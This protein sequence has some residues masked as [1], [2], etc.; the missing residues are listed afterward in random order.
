MAL[1]R[2]EGVVLRTMRLGEA[3][4]IITLATPEHGK[5]RAVAKG[6]RKTKSRIGARLE[7]LSHVTMLC[8]NGR[9]L[10]VVTQVEV[11]SSFRP[12]RE[13]LDRM[14]PAMT[15]LEIVDQ[16]AVERHPMPELFMMLVGALK[17]LA[18]SSSPLV[19]AGF[20]WRLLTIEGVAPIVEC[21]ARCGGPDPLVAFDGSEGG[22]LCRSCRRGQAVSPET[23]E[24]V[25]RI[26][27]GDLGGV[28]SEGPHG[29][30]DDVEHLA[31]SAVERHLDRRL[32][33]T[34]H[35]LDAAP[36]ASPSG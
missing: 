25:R 17:T 33:T 22:F 6:V 20:C 2:D 30:D 15:M 18:T 29:V 13:E 14:V 4:R 9:E 36:S 8:W 35:L 24:L 16:V 3:D 32:R 10:D 27:G 12:L 7:P 19:L 34:R 11:L 23:V 28:L 31:V 5:V 1:Y 26:V 21:C